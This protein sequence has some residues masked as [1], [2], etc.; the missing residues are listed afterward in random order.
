MKKRMKQLAALATLLMLVFGGCGKET[1]APVVTEEPEIVEE[2]VETEEVS[3][4][5][6]AGEEIVAEF[7]LSIHINTNRKTYYNEESED[8]YLYLQYCDVEV[9]TTEYTKLERNI[10]NWS[11]E[12]SEELRRFYQSFEEPT[13]EEV[14]NSENSYTYTLH[15]YLTIARADSAVVSL[16]DDTY[17]Y[18]SGN[19]SSTFYR[20]GI[21]FDSESGKRLGLSDIFYDY[22][23]FIESAKV[24]IVEELESDYSEQLYEDYLTTVENL[25]QEESEPEWYLDA[26]GIV[27][28]L[29]QL[30]VG[31]YSVGTPEICLPYTEFASYIKTAYLPGNQEGVALFKQNQEVY[32]S[33]PGA[34]EEVP[35]MLRS[36]LKDDFMY[37]SL[38]LG[39]DEEQ[40]QDYVVV[41]NAYIVR[42][43]GEIYCMVEVDEASDDYKTYIFRVTEG[44]L[45]K[46][47]EIYAAIDMG[48]ISAYEI[49]M[50]TAIYFLGT[51]GGVKSY[52]FDENGDFVT[53]DSEYLLY[54][55]EYAL[56]T[57]VDLPVTLEGAQSILPAGSHIILNATDDETYVKFT[58]QETGQTGVLQAE[59]DENDYYNLSINGMNEND[60]FEFLPYAG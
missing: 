47:D 24:R 45:E 29:Q 5:V 19:E 15:Q 11:M 21:N 12:R 31:P 16:L 23:G 26:S 32:L 52:H 40:L 59:R 46:V 44:T 13:S 54:K 4:E 38:W 30:S 20:K 49:R 58:I 43:D 34:E 33:L 22:E 6:P 56:T 9:E 3:E 27:I 41:Q 50:E 48:N 14:Q 17:Q 28:V 2:A 35:M 57:T 25:W 36:E 51:Y 18:I 7:P 10:E 1:E 60:C 55:N 53:E 39:N 8:A 42:T 37:N